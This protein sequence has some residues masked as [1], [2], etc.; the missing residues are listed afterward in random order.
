MQIG[1]NEKVSLLAVIATSSA[2]TTNYAIESG[3][4]G[5]KTDFTNFY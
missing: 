3:F 4:F 1:V 5:I 2:Q